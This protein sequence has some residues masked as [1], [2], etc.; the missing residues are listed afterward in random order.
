MKI[1][2]IVYFL[3]ATVLISVATKATENNALQEEC[4]SQSAVQLNCLVDAAKQML[5]TLEDPSSQRDGAIEVSLALH[6]VGR[7][8]EAAAM[9]AKEWRQLEV[10]EQDP[11]PHLAS[12]SALAVASKKAG[13]AALAR[14]IA[15]QAV[16]Y[17]GSMED[18]PKK[19]DSLG[20]LAQVFVAAGDTQTV[21][22]LIRQMPQSDYAY[23]AY[24]ARSIREV[25]AQLAKQ[26]AFD[27]AISW[28]AQITMGLPYYQA[29]ARTDVAQFA[30]AADKPEIAEKLIA[31]AAKM[32]PTF[33]NGYFVAGAL[34]EI[35]E[36][37]GSVG[38]SEKAA[39]YFE[40]A[41]SAA[42]L[43]PSKQ[44]A[45]RAVSR[46]STGLADH[47]YYDMA[48]KYLVRSVEIAED[49]EAD[50]LKSW[51]RYEV[52]G[53]L[54]F[55]GEFEQATGLLQEVP[56]ARFGST[57]SLHSAAA[58][59]VAWGF[60]RHG[61]IEEALNQLNEIETT[62]ERVQALSRIIRVLV[63]ADM[64]ALPRYL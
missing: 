53:S 11:L 41:F 29:T 57:Q 27:D 61:R 37:Y 44:E 64:Q 45:A 3:L 6:A 7:G 49:I 9:L 23:A 35:G 12:L 21:Q 14:D 62:R 5:D 34:R 1:L 28:I 2:L 8:D 58:R 47:G 16:A 30:M 32:A 24:K 26:G 22:E 46:V 63:N 56:R 42:Q 10:V 33:E 20:K 36:V 40:S 15:K 39:E 48:A 38:D 60:A 18:T 50:N 43:A 31:E 55:S 13:N 54:A 4:F 25:A 17:S 51:T 59:D 52:A 19:W